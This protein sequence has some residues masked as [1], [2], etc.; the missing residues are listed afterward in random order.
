MDSLVAW[1]RSWP[2]PLFERPV[3]CWSVDWAIGGWIDC[4][5]TLSA[6]QGI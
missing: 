6:S 2:C 3:I 1:A 5:T 4:A